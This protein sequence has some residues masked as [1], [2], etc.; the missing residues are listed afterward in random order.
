M[1][2]RFNKA[3]ER[4]AETEQA[5]C[6]YK[7]ETEQRMAA[8]DDKYAQLSEQYMDVLA[9]HV[10]VME[11]LETIGTQLQALSSPVKNDIL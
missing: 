8:L 10:A 5:F 6:V 11:K 4:L 2:H 1:E 9:K 3:L 7:Q